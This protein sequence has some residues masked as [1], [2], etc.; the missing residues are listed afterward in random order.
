MINNC[1]DIFANAMVKHY[2]HR[3][4]L[5]ESYIKQTQSHVSEKSFN[6]YLVKWQN[7]KLI[8]SAGRNWYSDIAEE[9]V[10]FTNP[11]S[12]LSL[13]L[14]D[15]F[16]L[17][18]FACWSTKQLT[19]FYHNLPGK[20]YTFIYV[21]RYAMRDVAIKLQEKYS[22]STILID[23]N[24]SDLSD[25][26]PK[27]NNFIIRPIIYDDRQGS[28][29]KFCL[30]IEKILVDLALESKALFLMDGKEYSNIL[31]NI[32]TFCRIKPGVIHRRIM[33]R[34]SKNEYISLLMKYFSIEC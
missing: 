29:Y 28:S 11:L 10:L 5:Y 33:R 31:N 21:E 7:E 26:L 32:A 15:A 24:K 9:F 4:L 27:G 22:S 30:D 14:R 20:F 6:R 1:V 17:L 13:F 23:P 3:S 18:E 2:C 19:N 12:E 25:F 8:F 34:K 16:P